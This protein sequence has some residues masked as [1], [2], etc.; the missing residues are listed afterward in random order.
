MFVFAMKL[1]IAEQVMETRQVI[2]QHNALPKPSSRSHN[3]DS[4]K[5]NRQTEIGCPM[6]RYWQCWRQIFDE[7]SRSRRWRGIQEVHIS[8]IAL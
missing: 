5:A 3:P 7:L 4:I 2:R 6:N 1:I 8:K